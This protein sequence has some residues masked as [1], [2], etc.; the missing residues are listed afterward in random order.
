RELR[1]KLKFLK[2]KLG[3]V[4]TTDGVKQ[5]YIQAIISRGDEEI[6]KLILEVLGKYG[7]FSLKLL[8]REMEKIGLDINEYARWG[9]PEKPWKKIKL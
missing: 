2:K 1:E 9:S 8:R 3:K 5:A 7:V 4:L 6:G